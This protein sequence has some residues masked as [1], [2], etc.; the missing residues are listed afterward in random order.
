MLKYNCLIKNTE[1]VKHIKAAIQILVGERIEDNRAAKFQSVYYDLRKAG[2]EID[3]ESA[4]KIYNILY[5]TMEDAD[6]LSTVEEVEEFAGIEFEK[7]LKSI[8]NNFTGNISAPVEQQLGDMAPEAYAVTTI[9][10]LFKESVFGASEKTSSNLK[11]MQ[12]LVTKAATSFLPKTSR[13]GVSLSDA[14]TSFFDIESNQFRT[15]SGQ[16]NTLETLYN[17]VKNEVA[18]YVDQAVDKLSDDEAD[19]FRALWDKYTRDFMNSAYDIVLNKG[20]Q[21]SL[22]NNALKQIKI[23]GVNIIDI[24]GN[25]KW[26]ALI[27]H[28]DPD[29]IA[30]KVSQ[31]FK[32][33]FFE[34]NGIHKFPESQADR[35]GD[36]FKRIYSDKLRNAQERAQNLNRLKNKSAKNIVSDFIKDRGYFNL[37]KDKNGK[38]LLSQ[39][40]WT[41]AMEFIKKQVGR[42]DVGRDRLENEI[43]GLDLIRN[44]LSVFLNSQTVN[45]NPKFTAEQKKQ[46]ED[47]LVNTIIAKL[48]PGTAEPTSLDRLIALNEINGGNAFNEETQQAVNNIVGVSGLN[49]RVLNQIRALTQISQ[50][51]INN[52][53]P[54]V[55]RGAYAYTALVEIDRRIKEIL[56]EHKIDSSMQ[57]RVIKYLADV[58]GGGTV[59]LLL[60][61]NNMIENVVTQTATNIGETVNMAFT[62]FPLFT[63][64]FGKLQGDFWKGWLNYAIGGASNEITNESDLS[65]DLQ[66]SERLRLSALAKEVKEKGI[67]GIGSVILKSPQYVVSIF[68]RAFMNSFDAAT[69]TALLRKKMI[70]ST[71]KALLNNGNSPAQALQIMDRSF[72]IP[73]SIEN[74]IR[75]ENAR[76]EQLLK[77]A[78]VSVN[79]VMMAQNA[80]DMRLSVY[81]DILR[82]QAALAGR[83]LKQATEAT[84]A[85]LESSH[86][87]AKMLG[88]KKVL[89]TKDWV[90]QIIYGSAKALLSPQKISFNAARLAENDGKLAKAA[91]Y[92]LAGAIYQ[93]S[94]GKFIGGVANFMVLGF[95]ATPIGFFMGGQLQIQ[96]NQA[97]SKSGSPDLFS[98]TPDEIKRYSELH[99]MMR[100]VYTRAIMGSIVMAAFIAYILAERAGD[101]DEEEEAIGWFANLMKTTSGRRFIQKHFPLAI[102]MVAPFY[103]KSDKKQDPLNRVFDMME[104]YAGTDFNSFTNLRKGL[105]YAKTDEDVA[106][107][108]G[109]YFGNMATTYNVNQPEQFLK[110]KDVIDSGLDSE[111]ISDVEENQDKSKQI[112]KSV[113]GFWEAFFLN[114]MIDALTREKYIRF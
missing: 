91:R 52:T 88:G 49:Q 33:G 34:N 111:K 84:K 38:L 31:L 56:R 80:N 45:G 74:E 98:A 67:K 101:D 23:D 41:N 81:E 78:G 37:V 76:I 100:S 6:L 15:L 22:V 39:A 24:N 64:T 58:M 62:N 55:N 26:S 40:D 3:A 95:S 16:V 79:S 17:A 71:Y 112:Y 72:K 47:E 48:E 103:Y 110:F 83:P 60:N 105:K 46:I 96:R 94:V 10:R 2:L 106:E 69:T 18:N 93:N 70:Q 14:L 21:N 53:T 5:G 87:Q 108:W 92:Q 51:V 104:A 90:S 107:V 59:S 44:R 65:S 113:E 109:K 61:P 30:E 42:S 73:A 35:I 99:G 43:R 25:V 114:G 13:P 29:T 54:S 85:L 19:T 1:A 9:S 28:N 63:K 89:P 8:V 7:Q 12:D 57:Q 66:S 77:S 97:L 102:S 50:S 86:G 4:G 36:Y 68:S 32:E 82:D 27:E 11:K 75:V 20:Q